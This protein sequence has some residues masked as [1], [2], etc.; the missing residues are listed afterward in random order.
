MLAVIWELFSLKSLGFSN[1][2]LVSFWVDINKANKSSS[3]C[4]G[5]C[6]AISRPSV[7][8]TFPL[9]K[10]NCL[11]TMACNKFV[12][13]SSNLIVSTRGSLV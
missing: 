7:C 6:E 2:L 11:S 1:L 12:L 5:K 9:F 13:S 8:S 3:C 4:G 10:R